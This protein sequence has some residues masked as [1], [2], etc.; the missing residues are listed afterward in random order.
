MYEDRKY[1][2]DNITNLGENDVFVFGSNL[3]G[4]HAGGAARIAREK[5][6]AIMGQGVGLQGQ[7]YAIPTMQGGVETIRPYVDEFIKFAAKNYTK[8]F[9]VTKIGCGIAGFS[10]E[11]I[12]PLF[13]DAMDLINVKLPVEFYRA[14]ENPDYFQSYL[15]TWLKHY[16]TYDMTLDLLLTANRM[17]R[18]TR[19]DKKTVIAKLRQLVGFH[20]RTYSNPFIEEMNKAYPGDSTVPTKENLHDYIDGI[21]D[22]VKPENPLDMPYYRHNIRLCYEVA[23]E[24]LE[25]ADFSRP[26]RF[27]GWSAPGDFYYT[28]YSLMTGRWNCGDNSYLSDNIE[29]AFPVIGRALED[30]WESLIDGGGYLSNSKIKA[31]FSN[32][33]LWIEWERLSEHGLALFRTIETILRHEYWDKNG[34]YNYSDT[35]DGIYYPRRDYSLPVYAR[36]RGRLHFPNFELKKAFIESLKRAKPLF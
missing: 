9:L 6:G 7:S 34:N 10:V 32:P 35:E 8:Q 21:A 28:F 36:Q 15:P 27:I 5:F 19:G 20:G 13:A 1:T 18:Y 4:N 11:E 16:T 3:A 31:L 22:R 29:Q 17:Y 12:A 23:K 30:N 2:P 25:V 33:A 14:L 24:M 26:D